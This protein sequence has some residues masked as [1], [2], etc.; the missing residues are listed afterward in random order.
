MPLDCLTILLFTD[1]PILQNFIKFHCIILFHFGTRQFICQ[2]LSSAIM[3]KAKPLKANKII[4]C[5]LG[6]SA[7]RYHPCC[8]SATSLTDLEGNLVLQITALW[9]DHFFLPAMYILCFFS[10]ISYKH[11]SYLSLAMVMSV[12][13]F[14]MFNC[15][16]PLHTF[17]S[18]CFCVANLATTLST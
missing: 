4:P 7:K 11:H 5:S 18:R 1:P 2:S 16:H 8:F 15:F 3:F 13:H 9:G 12:I 17:L 14:Y 10:F 6:S